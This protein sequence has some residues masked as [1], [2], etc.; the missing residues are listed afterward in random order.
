M[1]TFEEGTE[2][3]SFLETRGFP[4]VAEGE[5]GQAILGRLIDLSSP[6]GTMMELGDGTAT[7]RIGNQR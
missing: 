5:L 6:Y 3:P 1:P 2:G 4:E 7:L